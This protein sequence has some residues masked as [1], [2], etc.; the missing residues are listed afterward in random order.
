MAIQKGLQV[1]VA[2]KAAPPVVVQKAK[3]QGLVA[4]PQVVYLP[5]VPLNVPLPVPQTAPLA[6]SVSPSIL[7]GR[8]T[9]AMRLVL[10]LVFIALVVRLVGVQE[11]GHQ[12]YASLSTSELTQTVTIPAVRGGIYD[13]NG[14]VLAESV[15]KQTVVA[16]PLLINHPTTIAAALSPVLRIPTG[17]LRSELTEPSGFVYLAHRV[18]NAVAAKVAALN[19][20]GINLIP[21]SQRV[22]PDGQLAL[23]VVGT[24]RMERER[25][26]G[27][28]VPVPDD[29]GRPVGH[30][31]PVGVAR[32]AWPSPVTG[33]ARWPPGPAPGWS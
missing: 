8:R 5:Q 3:S 13:R 31:G 24:D 18:P 9:R 7:L 11:L 6:W 25:D 15:T 33:A 12:H 2:G 26:V 28:R 27:P 22:Q 19:L 29:A 10:A 1:E 14:E 32:A 17:R 21:E 16:D 30:R 20:A 4:S 23:P